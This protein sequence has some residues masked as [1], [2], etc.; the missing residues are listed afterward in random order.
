MWARERQC[1]WDEVTC[2]W[3]AKKGNLE[4]LQWAREQNCPWT[5]ATFRR[6]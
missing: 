6:G 1:P 2:Q 5:G 3:V 4:V